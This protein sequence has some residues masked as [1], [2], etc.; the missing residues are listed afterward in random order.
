M[1]Y[2]PTLLST[3]PL[4]IKL[5]DDE[6]LFVDPALGLVFISG[7]PAVA[8]LIKIALRMF[9]GEWFLNLDAG[10]RALE[11]LGQKYNADQFVAAVTP[12]VLAVP[13]VVAVQ[14]IAPSYDS[15]ARKA[16]ISF[17]AQAQFGDTTTTV[18]GTLTVPK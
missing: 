13:A 14:S 17:A 18:T 15:V 1:T 4:D 3:D 8:Q 9:V 2:I 11:M 16:S 5:K 7:L 10:D 6:D 12:V